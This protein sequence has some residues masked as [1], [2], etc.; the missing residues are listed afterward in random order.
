MRVGNKASS[1]TP[2]VHA[3]RGCLGRQRGRT[4]QHPP[5]TLPAVSPQAVI[6]PPLPGRKLPTSRRHQLAGGQLPSVHGGR[7]GLT[8][9]CISA[10][11]TST[12]A[13]GR[14][15]WLARN[16]PDF[17]GVPRGATSHRT[18]A[19]A[20]SSVLSSPTA[21]L[22]R[23]DLRN[24]KI[25]LLPG[26]TASLSSPKH[27]YLKKGEKRGFPFSRRFQESVDVILDKNRTLPRRSWSRV[28]FYP[29]NIYRA[30]TACWTL[31]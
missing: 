30:S 17:R 24:P 25:L 2:A 20:T 15:A 11:P 3:K 26:P 27:R 10:N 5:C 23:G 28:V 13:D 29:R 12:T 14:E 16:V 4:R 18:L 22:P 9:A 7:R 1:Q 6:W 21:S 31:V 19:P 8:V